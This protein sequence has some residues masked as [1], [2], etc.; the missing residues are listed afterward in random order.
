MKKLLFISVLFCITSTL[1]SQS[2]DEVLKKVGVEYSSAKPLQFNTKYNLYKNKTQKTAFESYVGQFKKNE[3]NEIYQKIDQTEFIWNKNI[4]LKVI[5]PDKIINIS[6]SQP[7]ELNNFDIKALKEWC[8]VKS[9]VDKKAYWELTLTTKAFSTLPYSKIVI[10]IGK[11][12]FIQKQLFYY[13]TAIDY[14]SDYKKQS[15][16]YPVL[17]I[18]YTNIK[19]EKVPKSFFNIYKYIQEKNKILNTTKA[20]NSYAIEDHREITFK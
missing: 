8:D 15:L 18:L 2:V 17:E 16:D 14:S 1:Y 19:R 20:Y 5:H 6:V 12:Y 3:K 13:N 7:V 11:N 9:F 10:H 4:C